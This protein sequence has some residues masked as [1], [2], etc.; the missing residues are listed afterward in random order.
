MTSITLTVTGA[1]AWAAVSGPLTSGM[2]GIPVTIEYDEAWEGLIKNLVCRC[3]PWESDGGEI[4][5]VLDVG[6]ASV[7]AHE[8]MQAGQYLHLGVEGFRED[9]SLVMP[10]TWAMCGE[11]QSGAN[12]DGDPSADPE[13]PVWSQL[14]AQIEQLDRDGITQE[15]MDEIRACAETAAQAAAD[16]G[17]SEQNAAAASSLAISSAN[18]AESFAAQ[19]KSSEEAAGASAASAANLANGALQ[20]QRAAEAAALRAEAAADSALLTSKRPARLMDGVYS[21]LAINHRGYST[22][23]PENTIPA[24]IKSREMG[25][26]YVEAD[27]SF[28]ADGVA[29]LL[30]DSTIDR[31]S[32]GSGS[33]SDLTYAEAS[34]YDY[35]S[36]KSAEYAGTRLPIFAEF[37][38][39]C[40]RIGL[41]PYIELKE[42]GAYTQE[43]IRGLVDTVK[44]CGMEGSVTWISFSVS[45]LQYVRAADPW[46]RLGFLVSAV[47][48]ETIRTALDLRTGRNEVFL[49]SSDYDGDA[50]SRCRAAELP[51]EIWT[52]NS[53]SDILG[54]DPYITGVTSDSLVAGKVL[55]DDAMVYHYGLSSGWGTE[56][57]YFELTAGQI[58]TTASTGY[59]TTNST[60][61][62]YVGMDCTLIPGRKYR[63][64]GVS[65]VRYGIQTI[66]ESGC[67]KIQ[68]GGDLVAGAPGDSVVD[69]LD[70]GWQDSGY[71]FTADAS[72]MCAWVCA[73]FA[74]NRNITPEQAMPVYLEEIG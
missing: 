32:N 35:G 69:K 39:L 31:T 42:N 63:L 51:L 9:G 11:I 56:Q 44:T 55:Q 66:T 2:V 58:Q 34:R 46:A 74:D 62:S 30:H 20:S 16:A 33:I 27:V 41:H 29:V 6:T 49:D 37:I 45:Y 64:V 53:A 15:R 54:M 43:Q 60:R 19:A 3:S 22:A 73:S 18:A 71:E 1:Q 5:T 65:G 68:S 26:H 50:V 70:S 52:I 36:W 40:K 23:A 67:V 10:T 72:A 59:L 12:T 24:Y 17:K 7:V 13:L 28:T 8:V 48:E 47:S 25:F 21:V 4:R 14:Q 57:F 38:V 61:V